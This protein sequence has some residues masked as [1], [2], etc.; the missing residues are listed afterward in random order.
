ME[1]RD[2]LPRGWLVTPQVYGVRIIAPDPDS[3]KDFAHGASRLLMN[4]AKC[5]GLIELTW[6]GCQSPVKITSEG[7]ERQQR[8]SSFSGNRQPDQSSDVAPVPNPAQP[9]TLNPTPQSKDDE[10]LVGAWFNQRPTG[11]VAIGSGKVLFMNSR[12]PEFCGMSYDDIIVP[13]IAALFEKRSE[14]QPDD[15]KVF[16]QR[17]INGKV[18]EGG[19]LKAFRTNGL[20]GKFH[21]RFSYLMFQGVPCRMSEYDGFE[22][23]V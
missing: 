14:Y 2:Y 21:G 11:I 13:D 8:R 19:E 15:L 22:V 16:H 6:D 18:M 5:L 1:L 9:S 12:M 10:I 7:Y 4:S 3:A 20:F 17:L 23:M